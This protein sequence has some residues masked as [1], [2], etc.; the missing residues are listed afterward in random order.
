MYFSHDEALELGADRKLA[1][2]FEALRLE[3]SHCLLD[4]GCGWGGMLR[5]SAQRDVKVT[6]L[7]LSRLQ[8]EYV[9]HKIA[10]ERLPAQVR[11]KTSSHSNQ[12]SGSMPFP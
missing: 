5:Y 10:E 9:D 11:T 7:T 4:V 12:P 3:P 2:A 6:G 8:K 1:L